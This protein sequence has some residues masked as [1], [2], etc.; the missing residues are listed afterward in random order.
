M[1]IMVYVFLVMGNAGFMS[2]TVGYRV[3][4]WWVIQ[5]VGLDFGLLGVCISG[6]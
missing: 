6:S 5:A 4:G 3:L 2:S 1:G